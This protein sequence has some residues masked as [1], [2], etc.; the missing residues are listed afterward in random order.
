MSLHPQD[1]LVVLK[2][3]LTRER[4]SYARLGRELGLSASQAHQAVKRA[5]LAGFVRPETLKV[6]RTALLEF[7]VHGLKYVFPP[8]R[9]PLVR[10]LPTAHSAPPLRSAISDSGTPVVWPDSD[11]T[12]RGESLKPLHKGAP[13][14][15]KQDE[16][17]YAALA[18]IDAI[19]AGRARERTL[20]TEKLKDLLAGG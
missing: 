2:L 3:A 9:G 7:I 4:Y 19:R 12:V 16:Q 8:Q 10:G 1:V 18:L 5:I 14:A 13:A 11:G 6:N 15:A 20:A 17:L